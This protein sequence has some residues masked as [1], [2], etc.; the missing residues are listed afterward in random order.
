MKWRRSTRCVNDE[1]CLE[2]WD[3]PDSKKIRDSKRG[4]RSPILTVNLI[5]WGAVIQALK[6]REL[7]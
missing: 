5:Q 4:N 1:N 6:N 3:L 2:V 7:D